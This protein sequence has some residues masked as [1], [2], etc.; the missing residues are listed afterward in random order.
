M[1]CGSSESGMG[2]Q[3][4]LESPQFCFWQYKDPSQSVFDWQG[5]SV[6]PPVPP[7][8]LAAPPF[9][10]GSAKPAEPPGA[11]AVAI[12]AV[13]TTAPADPACAGAKTTI[14]LPSQASRPASRTSVNSAE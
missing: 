12:P 13:P 11:P 7:L 9:P 14:S 4:P 5:L 2:K 8:P 3:T 10:P 1:N 6:L